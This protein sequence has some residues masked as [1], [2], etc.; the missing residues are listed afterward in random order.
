MSEDITLLNGLTT[1]TSVVIIEAILSILVGFVLALYFCWPQALV[2]LA[3]SPFLGAGMF[4]MSRLQWG[5]KGGSGGSQGKSAFD[6]NAYE[7][8][9]ALL[10][11]II[12]NYKTVAA[13]GEKNV[14]L[15]F[16][17][18]EKLMEEPLNRRI[19]NAHLAGIAHGY[20]QCARMI[21]MGLIFYLGSIMITRFEYDSESVYLCINVLMHAA[22]GIGMSMSNIPSV[23]RAK[24]SAKT[25]FDVIDE[26]S[27]LDVRE[28]AK[29]KL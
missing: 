9:N 19:K 28:G 17:K 12:I 5:N 27:T 22:F 14:E 21:F 1:E 29:A 23:Q 4:V 8:A 26:K 11:D 2:V 16:E 6:N 13:F 3:C 10:S 24:A 20:S 18:Y 15:I 7:K 25:I